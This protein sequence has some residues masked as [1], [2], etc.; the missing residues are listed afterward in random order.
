MKLSAPVL[1]GAAA[2]LGA[3]V[4]VLSNRGKNV[5]PS[6]TPSP[7]SG[8]RGE[9]VRTALE[10]VQDPPTP[11]QIWEDTAPTLVGSGAAYCGGFALWVLHQAGLFPGLPWEPGKGFCY[12]LPRTNLPEPGD[13]AYFENLQHHAVVIEIEDQNVTTVDGNQPGIAIRKRPMSSVTAFFSIS[14]ALAA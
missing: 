3:G 11:D 10:A 12:K 1:L 6:P 5:I 4:L 2:A 9:V 14:P 8:P 13:I 7:V